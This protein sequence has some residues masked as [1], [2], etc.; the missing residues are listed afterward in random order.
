MRIA[1]EPLFGYQFVILTLMYSLSSQANQCQVVLLDAVD[2]QVFWGQ[3]VQGGKDVEF[4]TFAEGVVAKSHKDDKL[5]V[6]S[7]TQIRKLPLGEK[8]KNSFL[9]DINEDGSR[10]LLETMELDEKND[11][12]QRFTVVDL[13]SGEN[14]FDE[15]EAYSNTHQYFL[16]GKQTLIEIDEIANVL[17]VIDLSQSKPQTTGFIQMPKVVIFDDGALDSM[18]FSE[19]LR[20]FISYDEQS[21]DVYMAP[22][23][24]VFAPKLFKFK[25]VGKTYRYVGEFELEIVEGQLAKEQKPPMTDAKAKR[26]SLQ[27]PGSV[28]PEVIKTI[29]NVPNSTVYPQY[30][31][32]IEIQDGKYLNVLTNQQRGPSTQKFSM[33]YSYDLESGKQLLK[34]KFPKGIIINSFSISPQR[35]WIIID[36]EL[37]LSDTNGSLRER[38][39]GVSQLV[40]GSRVSQLYLHGKELN[41]LIP[42]RGNIFFIEEFMWTSSS[43]VRAISNH[44]DVYNLSLSFK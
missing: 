24:E 17:N 20:W 37:F 11:I 13:R 8:F 14:L 9:I 15:I 32:K 28:K 43:T 41:S 40:S 10:A 42:A 36:G 2:A 44:F 39:L 7:S 31:E 19:R 21:G 22:K 12:R 18:G 27:M 6:K 25:K 29:A 1:L 5:L 35:E 16:Q 33:L 23:G 38:I 3:E 34:I 26:L 4:M 30:I